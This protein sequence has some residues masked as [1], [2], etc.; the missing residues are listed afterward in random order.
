MDR[1][2]TKVFLNKVSHGRW[3]CLQKRGITE[4]ISFMPVRQFAVI[5]EIHSTLPV[6]RALESLQSE[7]DRESIVK[8]FFA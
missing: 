3:F 5:G 6:I 2:E 8:H 4:R 7:Y 1:I